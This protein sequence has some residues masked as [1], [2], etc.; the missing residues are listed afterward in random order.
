[1]KSGLQKL[2][3]RGFVNKKE[4]EAFAAKSEEEWMALLDAANPCTRTV[5]AS[6]LCGKHIPA[7]KALLTRLKQEQCLYTRLAICES[8][9]KGGTETAKIMTPYLGEIGNNQ[10]KK[11]PARP[12]A[13]RSYPLARDVTARTMGQMDVS[14][15]PVLVKVLQGEDTKK[16]SEALDAAGYMAFYHPQLAEKNVQII[17]EVARRYSDNPLLLWKAVLCLSAFKDAEAAKLLRELAVRK[18]IIGAE[19]E[20]SLSFFHG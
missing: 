9:K 11:P 15:F 18:D 1:M 10:Y 2:Q 16:I 4:A 8:L 19:A 12:S 20:R 17:L 5:A 7:A 3:K 6:R 13:K 14:I